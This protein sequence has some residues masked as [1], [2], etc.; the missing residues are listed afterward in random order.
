MRTV[1]IAVI[2][3]AVC[4]FGFL[5][6]M[7]PATIRY[8]EAADLLV[9][10]Y[11]N[12]YDAGDAAYIYANMLESALKAAAKPSDIEAAMRKTGK[13]RSRKQASFKLLKLDGSELYLRFDSVY[14]RAQA[15][16]QFT[17][18]RENGTY[19]FAYLPNDAFPCSAR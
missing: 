13:L 2:A 12:R 7:V 15:T 3:L 1:N 18:V 5:A 4:F 19:R 17:L 14:D 11:Y 6:Y 10:E 9:G 16:D 8:R